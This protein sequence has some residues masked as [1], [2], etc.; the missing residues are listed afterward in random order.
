MSFGDSISEY[1]LKIDIL[2]SCLSMPPRKRNIE[3]TEIS[4]FYPKY[5]KIIDET[6][7]YTVIHRCFKFLELNN[8]IHWC[9]ENCN[10]DWV[11]NEKEFAFKSKN[12]ATLFK[13]CLI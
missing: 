11:F 2:Y 6:F 3:Q 10:E 12:D 7:G 1:F 4:C 8:L 13:L 5:V 9:Q